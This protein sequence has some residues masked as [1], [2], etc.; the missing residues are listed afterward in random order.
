M[1][2]RAIVAD[3]RRGMTALAVAQ[4]SSLRGMPLADWQDQ[5]VTS[6]AGR[7]SRW[8][9]GA[10]RNAT[11]PGSPANAG[12]RSGQVAAA[13]FDVAIAQAMADMKAAAETPAY[14]RHAAAI[15]PMLAALLTTMRGPSENR[16]DDEPQAEASPAEPETVPTVDRQRPP[17]SAPPYVDSA[18]AA[19]DHRVQARRTRPYQR[20][21]TPD[22]SAW[23]ALR[24]RRCTCTAPRRR[25]DTAAATGMT[26]AFD[27]ATSA[28]S[29]LGTTRTSPDPE[30]AGNRARRAA[31][32]RRDV[33]GPTG[34]GGALKVVRA[35]LAYL[36]TL[37]SSFW[38]LRT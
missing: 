2:G 20:S 13:Q 27:T 7:P 29:V 6:D 16:D 26:L 37:A 1:T 3:R 8:A 19:V 35:A 5:G 23:A 9:S 14:R 12:R 21:Q 25:A 31:A 32:S 36:F 17:E 38:A 28:P 11:A 30:R 34:A 24:Q 33:A 4:R 15:V 18:R 10:S 22:R